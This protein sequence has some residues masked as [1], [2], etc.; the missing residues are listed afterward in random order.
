MIIR[1]TAL[2]NRCEQFKVS[3]I[4]CLFSFASQVT[5]NKKENEQMK[6]KYVSNDFLCSN[7]E[8]EYPQHVFI[9]SVRRDMGIFILK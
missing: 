9:L 1:G 8:N 6:T 7:R 2:L 5:L 4:P 3:Y